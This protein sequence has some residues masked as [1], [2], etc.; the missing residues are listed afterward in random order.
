MVKAISRATSNSGASLPRLRDTE[1]CPFRRRSPHRWPVGRISPSMPLNNE[2][3][4][5]SRSD[6]RKRLVACGDEL[7]AA[8]SAQDE[9]MTLGAAAVAENNASFHQFAAQIHASEIAVQKIS[10]QMTSI[11]TA[12]RERSSPAKMRPS[13]ADQTGTAAGMASARLPADRPIEGVETKQIES[14]AVSRNGQSSPTHRFSPLADCSDPTYENHKDCDDPKKALAR[15]LE[16]AT[17]SKADKKAFADSEISRTLPR[18][19]LHQANRAGPMLTKKIVRTSR[20]YSP[21]R[22]SPTPK[23]RSGSPKPRPGSPLMKR[24]VAKMNADQR[25]KQGRQTIA[26]GLVE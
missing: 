12:M 13:A 15:F 18:S 24:A 16:N 17:F 5:L 23:P 19:P 8:R 26:L 7:E 6:L 21:A 2:M 3:T 25:A 10:L 11:Q 22:A 1:P 4:A 20:H 9:A 14:A